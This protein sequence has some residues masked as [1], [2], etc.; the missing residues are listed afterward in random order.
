MNYHIEILENNNT[1]YMRNIGPYGTSE[2]FKM[3]ADLKNWISRHNLQKELEDF[4]IWGIA[5]DNPQTTPPN[6]C[7]YD[8]LLC[9]HEGSN[10]NSDEVKIGIF[11]GGKYAV[12]T[13]LHTTKAV[14]KFWSEI[15]SHIIKNKLVTRDKPIIERFKED[16][17]LDK[18]CQFLIPIQ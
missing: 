3:M 18:Y 14:Q 17:G 15:D 11:E 5:L 8:L 16:E 1:V 4:G 6:N 9:T 13:I 7:R 2:N 10:F 12:F